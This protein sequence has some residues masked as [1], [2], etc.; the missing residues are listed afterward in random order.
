MTVTLAFLTRRAAAFD[1]LHEIEP[2]A[3]GRCGD[4]EAGDLIPVGP[5]IDAF[6]QSVIGSPE[7]QDVAGIG[8]HHEPFAI[9]AAIFIPAHFEWQTDARPSLPPIC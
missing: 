5:I 2:D 9:R 8:V 3:I 7:E 1:K 6:P 4:G